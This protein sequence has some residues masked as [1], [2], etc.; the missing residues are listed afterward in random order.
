MSDVFPTQ[1]C[2]TTNK[3]IPHQLVS[4]PLVVGIAM[5]LASATQA[6]TFTVTN[7]NDAGVGS[8]RQAVIDANNSTG[9]DNIIFDPNLNSSTITLTTGE[10]EVADDLTISGPIDGYAGSIILD[11]NNTSRHFNIS[12]DPVP[13]T[14]EN[15]T[16]TQGY[17]LKSG[18]SVRGGLLTLNDTVVS[19][20]RVMPVDSGFLL[21]PI[22]YGGGLA[23][24]SIT[25]NRSTVSSNSIIGGILSDGGGLSAFTVILNESTV[26]GNSA[27]FGGGLSASKLTLKQSTISGNTAINSGGGI[28]A[29]GLGFVRLIQST[30]TDNTSNRGAG[31]LQFDN[32]GSNSS[33]STISL[34]N[35]ILADNHGPEGNFHIRLFPGRNLPTVNARNS[36][37]GDNRSE[38]K[39]IRANNIFSNTPELGP[40]QFNSGF[41]QTH[42][43]SA[44]SPVL[45]AGDN[46][47][48]SATVDQRGLMR[49]FNGIVDIGA[50]ERQPIPI[51][52]IPVF[53]V[54]G[55]LALIASLTVLAG[56]RQRS[57]KS[58]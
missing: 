36:V 35:T 23:A 50:V 9:A 43:P 26:S 49:I 8:L 13:L 5:V 39:D 11:G 6:T 3:I 48:T 32:S 21:G 22:S 41:T 51:R 42:L 30:I 44:T 12:V 29:S 18:G 28:K 17:G 1:H 37:F 58:P 24:R 40:L 25:L 34:I 47:D 55:L 57:Q 53:S 33:L 38:I 4:K 54:P 45:D 52:P 20:N 10:I 31:G 2:S 7:T 15:L 19:K 27:S 14:L 46:A 56:W 16:L